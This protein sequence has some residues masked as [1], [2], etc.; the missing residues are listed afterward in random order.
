MQIPLPPLPEQRSIAAILDKANALRAKRRKAISKLNQLLQSIFLDMFGDPTTNPK[1]WNVAQ[2]KDVGEVQGGLQLSRARASLP[3]QAPYLRVA[4]VY[5]GRLD[6]SEIKT[7]GVTPNELERTSLL[8]NDILIVEGHGNP[9]E[10]GR[11]A[12]WDGSIERCSHQN[13][14]IRLCIYQSK[15]TAAFISHFLNSHGGRQGLIDASNTTS[16]LNTISVRKV[17][18]CRI[19]LPPFDLQQRFSRITERV[20]YQQRALQRHS[21]QLEAFFASL[22]HSVFNGGT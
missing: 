2:V 15:A 18:E 5:R 11:C 22:Q 20:E 12:V 3:I 6:L 19:F 7:F 17:R 21:D 16:G 10:I 14:L 9:M 4:N 13:H 8:K 1:K